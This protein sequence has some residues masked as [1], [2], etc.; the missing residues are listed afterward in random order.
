MTVMDL[1]T[2]DPPAPLCGL[3]KQRSTYA[4]IGEFL[5]RGC[6]RRC[7]G[8]CQRHRPPDG[9]DRFGGARL[10]G[11]RAIRGYRPQWPRSGRKRAHPD[12]PPAPARGRRATTLARPPHHAAAGL[13][14]SVAGPHSPRRP[15]TAAGRTRLPQAGPAGR[16]WSVRQVTMRV[17]RGRS[18]SAVVGEEPRLA[19]IERAHPD[20]GLT[21]DDEGQTRSPSGA[22]VGDRAWRPSPRSVTRV[23]TRV[24]TSTSQTSPSSVKATLPPSAAIEMWSGLLVTVRA[25]GHLSLSSPRRGQPRRCATSGGRRRAGHRPTSSRRRR[26]HRTDQGRSLRCR[27]RRL[28][29]PR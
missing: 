25:V 4:G 1:R 13:S 23:R 11:D 12:R 7:R 17:R 5:D 16:R 21:V 27:G 6:R 28:C 3:R 18:R 29:P 22:R 19:A 10:S 9:T 2:F 15:A 8:L 26:T 14:R 24:S 20:P